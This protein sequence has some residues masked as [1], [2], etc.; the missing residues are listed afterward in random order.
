MS[1]DPNKKAAAGDTKYS[2]SKYQDIKVSQVMGNATSPSGGQGGPPDIIRNNSRQNSRQF[3][4][5][6]YPENNQNMNLNLPGRDNLG[7][8]D[9]SKSPR[10]DGRRGILKPG[11]VSPRGVGK[12]PISK[13]YAGPAGNEPGMRKSFANLV[14]EKGLVHQNQNDGGELTKSRQQSAFSNLVTKILNDPSSKNKLEQER[15]N[16]GNDQ[17]GGN[18]GYDNSR[19]PPNDPYY[20]DRDYPGGQ[21]GGYNNNDRRRGGPGYDNNPRAGP[22]DNRDGGYGGRP[23]GNPQDRYDNRGA[24]NGNNYNNNQMDRMN[25]RSMNNPYD[26]ADK[27]SKVNDRYPDRGQGADRQPPPVGNQQPRGRPGNDRAGGYPPQD[28]AG[29]PPRDGPPNSYERG[30]TP[31]KGYGPDRGYPPRDSQY[32]PRDGQYPPRDAYPPREGQLP[33]RDVQYPSRDGQYPSRD[34]QYPPREPTRDPPGYGDR[35]R[36]PYGRGAQDPPGNY[37]SRGGN[38]T[39][40]NYPP[41]NN[42]PPRRG[43]PN[44]PPAYGQQPY[45]RARSQVVGANPNDPSGGRYGNRYASPD[46]YPNQYPPEGE[47]RNNSAEPFPRKSAPLGGAP[48]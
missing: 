42:M 12:A 5:N 6:Q 7:K 2:L 32:P 47:R 1:L 21:G 46:V 8:N 11:E 48:G 38:P 16:G 13:S 19:Y 20:N 18:D 29:L 33:P 44:E 25:D 31:E 39:D 10:G 45:P 34:G 43:G 37:N 27:K 23:R 22:Q 4:N 14:R 41:G 3:S 30:Y 28:R 24:P 40:P 35:S 9:G 36:S 26:S 17:Y 15:H